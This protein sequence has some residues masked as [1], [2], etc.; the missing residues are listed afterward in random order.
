LLI[1]DCLQSLHCLLSGEIGHS[2]MMFLSQLSHLDLE[3][4]ILS[5][6]FTPFAS[7]SCNEISSSL[8]LSSIMIC[9]SLTRQVR[10]KIVMLDRFSGL[11]ILHT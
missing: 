10:C 1:I 7:S 3:C 4:F 8:K 11:S 2:L 9:F 5:R 6:Q